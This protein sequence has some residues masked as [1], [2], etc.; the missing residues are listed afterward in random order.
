MTVSTAAN[1]AAMSDH[2]HAHLVTQTTSST[3]IAASPVQIIAFLAWRQ[4]DFARR[5]QVNSTCL[6]LHGPAGRVRWEHRRAL[7]QPFSNVCLVT[8]WSTPSVFSAFPTAIPVLT[9]IPAKSVIPGTISH[10]NS[11]ARPA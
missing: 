2:H 7:F 11:P 6:N 8:T 5:V 1:P 4:P 9:H 10:L 3:I